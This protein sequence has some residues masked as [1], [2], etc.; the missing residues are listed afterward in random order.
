MLVDSVD[1][2]NKVLF[3]SIL[4]FDGVGDRGTELKD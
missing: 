2:D 1:G 4:N 3:Y